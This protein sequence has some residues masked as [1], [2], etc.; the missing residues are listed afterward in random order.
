MVFD[1]LFLGKIVSIRGYNFCVI[2]Y[3][4]EILEMM[5]IYQINM[6]YT[7]TDVKFLPFKDKLVKNSIE[8]LTKID[9]IPYL[10]RFKT[11]EL[12]IL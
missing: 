5:P 9:A 2:G 6:N 7:L 12:V 8:G 3:V 4:L 1:L 11:E 10:R